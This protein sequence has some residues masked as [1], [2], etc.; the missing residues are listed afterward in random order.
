MNKILI[1]GPQ[2]FGQGGMEKIIRILTEAISSIDCFYYNYHNGNNLKNEWLS[3]AEFLYYPNKLLPRLF[4]E[5]LTIRQLCVFIRN[6]N[7]D[8]VI[9]LDD[10]S[11]LLASLAKKFHNFKLV[12]WLHRSI[13]TFKH[14]EY[15]SL[16]DAHISISKSI[17]SDIEQITRSSDNIFLL[18]NCFDT[19]EINY[20]AQTN[21]NK[22]HILYIGRIE[23]EG[24]KY[25]KD[26]ITA[27]S[28]TT[29]NVHLD[30][31]GDGP[32]IEK[33]KLTK[34]ITSLGLSSRIHFHGWKQ[35]PWEYI[36]QSNLDSAKAL[37]L[38]STY[39]GFPLIII[40]A[41]SQGFFVISSDCPTGPNEIITRKNGRLFKTHDTNTLASLLDDES[42][43][44]YKS[45]EIIATVKDFTKDS[46]ITNFN[47][48]IE[49]IKQK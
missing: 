27:I 17:S 29:G 4:Q 48:I 14:K 1:F 11:C 12:T 35:N 30:I 42:I 22:D 9:C 15:L 10:K 41:L 47:K 13:H 40:E 49:T 23:Y 2:P 16:A 24:Q 45:Q 38:T 19:P 31:I 44:N 32:E 46:Y 21:R 28:K 33:N 3:G 26:L 18:Y 43:T 6:N 8:I 20:S 34:Q 5:A 37:C 36:K 25:L 7:P 39:E